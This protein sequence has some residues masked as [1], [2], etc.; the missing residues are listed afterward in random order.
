[1]ALSKNHEYHDVTSCLSLRFNVSEFE[2]FGCV[3]S[4]AVSVGGQ[5]QIPSTF[6]SSYM[7]EGMNNSVVNP[8][9][10]EIPLNST[11]KFILRGQGSELLKS[12]PALTLSFPFFL[13]FTL[14]NLRR[15]QIP[16][17]VN[18]PLYGNLT[19]C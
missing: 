7:E 10:T 11:R 9:F 6:D 3:S 17:I 16:Y 19:L 12:L 8:K 1:M 2:I 5:F 13:Q 18:L 15:A 14:P 4:S